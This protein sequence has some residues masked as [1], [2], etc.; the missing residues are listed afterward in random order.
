MEKNSIPDM[1]T[2]YTF[3]HVLLGGASLCFLCLSALSEDKVISNKLF[4]WAMIFTMAFII[5]KCVQ[6]EK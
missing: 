1:K 4:V 6:Y 3:G 5:V 2:K